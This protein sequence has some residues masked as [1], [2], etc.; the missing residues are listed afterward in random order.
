MLAGRE[1]GE[2]APA[3]AGQLAAYSDTIRRASAMHPVL[4]SISRKRSA[5]PVLR[6]LR[7]IG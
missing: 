3:H 2:N 1:V 5:A 4:L 7:A 6:E